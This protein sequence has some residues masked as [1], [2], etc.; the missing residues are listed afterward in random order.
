M[1]SGS[2]RNRA[3]SVRPSR[4]VICRSN[5]RDPYF[6][7]YSIKNSINLEFFSITAKQL[8]K[9]HWSRE[10]SCH[11]ILK[12]VDLAWNDSQITCDLYRNE[13]RRVQSVIYC[14]KSVRD[15]T[16][17]FLGNVLHVAGYKWKKIH[18]NRRGRNDP[19]QGQNV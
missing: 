5:F 4:V 9:F 13:W 10:C 16:L 1:N 6:G 15:P 19:G 8:T 3:A 18:K 11:F 17:I 7:Q 12:L 2:C 14:K